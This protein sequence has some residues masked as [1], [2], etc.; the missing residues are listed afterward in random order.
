MK[1]KTKPDKA[2]KG[3]R[4]LYFDIETAP[5]LAWV[6]G[7][8]EQNVIKFVSEGYLLCFAYKWHGEDKVYTVDKATSGYRGMLRKLRNLFD[9][10]DVIIA[11]NGDQ[12]DIK[13]ANSYFARAGLP[14]PSPY[15]TI[16]TKKVA[17]RH[18]RFNSN[19]LTD[20]GEYLREGKKLDTGGFELWEGVMK[21]D[22]AAWKKMLEYNIQDVLLLERVYLRLR[23]WMSNHPD[24]GEKEE[25]RYCASNHVQKRGPQTTRNTRKQGIKKQRIQCMDCG[26]WD[27]RQLEASVTK[28]TK[29]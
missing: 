15:K 8:Y 22:K 9:E 26:A 3:K 25:C 18:F 16:D 17:K 20:L 23:P 27:T 7:K 11:H 10:A 4:I 24:V 6:W 12:F 28:V 5:N 19:K 2:S 21:N 14:P 13:T 29:N 1:E